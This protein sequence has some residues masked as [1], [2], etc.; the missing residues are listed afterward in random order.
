MPG[1]NCVPASSSIPVFDVGPRAG[2]GAGAALP[3]KRPRPLGYTSK[4]IV[5][6]NEARAA[7]GRAPLA[8]ASA[9]KPMTLTDAGCS[10]AGIAGT[11][12]LRLLN[13]PHWDWSKVSLRRRAAAIMPGR[14]WK[15]RQRIRSYLCQACRAVAGTSRGQRRLWA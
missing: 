1:M 7:L 2:D 4:G 11:A 3:R 12:N 13:S 5:T 10:T 6:I 8:E 14:R 15:F 9:N